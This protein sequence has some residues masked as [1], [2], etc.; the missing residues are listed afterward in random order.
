M[1]PM[2]AFIT[3][4]MNK[5]PRNASTS[6]MI[7]INFAHHTQDAK[8]AALTRIS[9]TQ[10]FHV[11]PPITIINFIGRYKHVREASIDFFMFQ[12]TN[13]TD[14]SHRVY[15]G[16]TMLIQ[17]TP[18]TVKQNMKQLIGTIQSSNEYAPVR[19]KLILNC[20]PNT[21]PESVTELQKYIHTQWP[22]KS[23]SYFNLFVIFPILSSD[24]KKT[25]LN[26]KPL[27]AGMKN[28]PL[29]RFL[30]DDVYC[31]SENEETKN[32]QIRQYIQ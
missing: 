16:D 26:S 22:E 10:S 3:T 19:P 6:L 28:V 23:V 30:Y 31:L 15:E 18:A 12:E 9:A 20:Y 8:R 25:I 27:I 32:E 11:P 24:Y 29:R 7:P 13:R 17:T 5:L 4:Q 21:S 2:Y 14:Q 1:Y